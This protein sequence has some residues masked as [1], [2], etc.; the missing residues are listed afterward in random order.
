MRLRNAFIRIGLFA[1]AW[2]AAFSVLPLWIPTLALMGW[3]AK[4]TPAV[5]TI[6]N[7]FQNVGPNETPA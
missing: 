1:A 5:R 7:R 2:V 6:N 4:I 3:I